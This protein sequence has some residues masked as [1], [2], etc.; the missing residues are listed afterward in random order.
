MNK[1]LLFLLFRKIKIYEESTCFFFLQG[2]IKVE[3]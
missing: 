3:I 2:D 1:V